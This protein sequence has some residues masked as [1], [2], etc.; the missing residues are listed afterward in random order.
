MLRCVRIIMIFVDNPAHAANWWAGFFEAEVHLDVNGSN[1]Y[2][3]LEID[4]VE[5]GFHQASA[6]KNPSGRS[7]VPYWA[8]DDLDAQRQLFL[9]AGCAHLR[10]PLEISPGRRVCQLTDPFGTAFGL[11]G[12]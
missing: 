1:V 10:G 12:P 6:E 2:A 9:D 8:V 3:W 5:L 7:T 11:E 4:G